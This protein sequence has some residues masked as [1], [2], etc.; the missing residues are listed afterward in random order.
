MKVFKK[1]LKWFG[2]AI[3]LLL[4]VAGSLYMIYLRPFIEKMKQINT[5]QYDTELTIV[6]G[7]GGNSG[8]L[9]SDSLVLVIDTK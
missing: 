8:I 7:G 5:I 9:T 1:I 3:L 4:V 2:V 6:E